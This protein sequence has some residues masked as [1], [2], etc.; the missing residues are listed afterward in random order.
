MCMTKLETNTMTAE[1]RIGSQRSVRG[2]MRSLLQVVG[3]CRD[4]AGEVTLARSRGQGAL[5]LSRPTGWCG[6][7]S[8]VVQDRRAPNAPLMEPLR[9]T[10]PGTPEPPLTGLINTA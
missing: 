6:T 5:G 2:T 1:S 8:T 10:P 4:F 9:S 3:E 7:T